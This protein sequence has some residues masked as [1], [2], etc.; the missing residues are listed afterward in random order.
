MSDQL[1]ITSVQHGLAER[2]SAQALRQLGTSSRLREVAEGFEAMFLSQ[3]FAH[4]YSGIRSDGMFGG[5][6]AEQM[7]RSL[8]IDEYAK[9]A[10]G[11]GGIGIADAVYRELLKLQ[12]TPQGAH[13]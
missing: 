11:T 1:L 3:M 8:Q 4:M 13:P 12:E 9:A 10:A 6:Q 5:G 7:F 2:A